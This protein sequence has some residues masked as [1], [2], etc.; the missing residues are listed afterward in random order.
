MLALR[1]ECLSGSS[2][3]IFS[4]LQPTCSH[5]LKQAVDHVLHEPEM[6]KEIEKDQRS[7]KTHRTAEFW[8]ML[9]YSVVFDFELFY[10]DVFYSIMSYSFWLVLFYS[11]VFC[12]ILSYHILFYFI[13]LCIIM[14]YSILFCHILLGS[15]I[16]CTILS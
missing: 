4:V 13:L 1:E 5:R 6:E 10:S 16:L 11:G 15:V 12:S 3:M 7:I 8:C 2:G 9:F 14:L